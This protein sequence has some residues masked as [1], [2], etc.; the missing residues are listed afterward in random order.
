[1]LD[2]YEHVTYESVPAGFNL[3][4]ASHDDLDRY[5]IPEKPDAVAEPRLF[6]FWKKLVSEPFSSRP[7]TFSDAETLNYASQALAKGSTG[8]TSSPRTVPERP[9]RGTVDWSSNWSGAI[10]YPPFPRRFLFATAGWV[11]PH[12]S[13]PSE[14]ALYT[15]AN[16]P[17]AMVWVGTDGYHGM[18]PRIS[19]PQIGTAHWLEGPFQNFAWW[20]WWCHPSRSAVKRIDNFAIEPGDEI[21]AGLAVLI[22]EDIQFFIKNQTTG[23]FRSFLAKRHSLPHPIYQVGS[24]V[25]WVVERPTMPKSKKYFPL[26]DYGSVDFKYCMAVAAESKRP[27]TTRR[28]MTLADNG[29]IIKM[30]EAFADPY[31]S[32]YVSSARRRDDPDGSV[33]VTCTFR[34]PYECG[35]GA[36]RG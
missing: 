36:V 6:E 4:D 33:G 3:L 15:D 21:L 8:R 30:S 32:A 35:S 28:L 31:R 1:M 11:V 25:E 16:V 10:V 22:S 17:K 5:G 19:L 12:V 13:A 26:A 24:S 18:R 20:D 14:T 29:R 7:P 27:R 34:E 23:E 9:A 2:N